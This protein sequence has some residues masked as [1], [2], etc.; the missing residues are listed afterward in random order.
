[1]TD[2][3]T[4]NPGD[5]PAVVPAQLLTTQQ[6]DRLQRLELELMQLAELQASGE[7]LP[8]AIRDRLYTARLQLIS[9]GQI[10]RDLKKKVE[11][12]M[13]VDIDAHGR[14]EAGEESLYVAPDRTHKPIDLFAVVEALLQKVG[15]DVSEFV[16][17]LASDAIK[18][19]RARELLGESLFAL[20][21]E[22]IEKRDLK[23][24]PIKA[25]QT[26]NKRF[27]KSRPA[28]APDAKGE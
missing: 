19:G 23:G 21:F 24:K 14:Y 15:G 13:I 5:L 28:I 11:Q 1:M 8:A 10:Q 27:V 25:L 22:T 12:L 9:A 16:S 17:C 2:D 7:A 6:P 4:Q 18:P 26:V 3:T 20:L